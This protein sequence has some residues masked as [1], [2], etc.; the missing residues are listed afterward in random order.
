MLCEIRT[1]LTSLNTDANIDDI[2]KESV[3]I[4]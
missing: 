2:S 3:E 4:F 1:T